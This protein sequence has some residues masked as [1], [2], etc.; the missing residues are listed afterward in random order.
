MKINRELFIFFIALALT[1]SSIYAQPKGNSSSNLSMSEKMSSTVKPGS[2]VAADTTSKL[3]GP[4]QNYNFYHAS[5]D[6]KLDPSQLESGLKDADSEKV[7]TGKPSDKKIKINVRR[8]QAKL[9]RNISALR[10]EAKK[11][12]S[13]S[14]N[15]NDIADEYINYAKKLEKELNKLKRNPDEVKNI[16][17]SISSL[18]EESSLRL[19][20]L[21]DKK[22]QAEKTLS[23]VLKVFQNTQRDLV[24]NLK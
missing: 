11:I 13:E 14:P 22:D 17:D 8:Y 18:S 24:S 21:M 4:S 7:N 5:P 6:S 2:E 19:Q 20:L 3:T 16:L 15:L 10:K 9:R 1:C 23:N 12:Q